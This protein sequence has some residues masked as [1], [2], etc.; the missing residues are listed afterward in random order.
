MSTDDI[1]KIGSHNGAKSTFEILLDN[2]KF[3]LL[4]T[5]LGKY[6]LVKIAS[7]TSSHNALKLLLN[8]STYHL[9]V[10][11]LGH[12]GLVKIANS[13]SSKNILALFLQDS[14]YETLLDRVGQESMIKLATNGASTYL[15]NC[16][17][18]NS[19]YYKLINCI[20][21]ENLIKIGRSNC[22]KPILEFI[23]NKKLF[24][25]LSDKIGKNN[26]INIL[27]NIRDKQ[28]ISLISNQES[29]HKLLDRVSYPE[30]IQV[31]RTHAARNVLELILDNEIFDQLIQHLGHRGLL[32]IARHDGA[33][34]IF[35]FVV[36]RE[37]FSKL[38]SRITIAEFLKITNQ[39]GGKLVLDL[40]L[41][42]QKWTV[43][44]SFLTPGVL[45]KI[46][47][48]HLLKSRLEYFFLNHQTL[49]Q[50][51]SNVFIKK[52]IPLSHKD[53]N[54][55][56]SLTV[57]RLINT[58]QFTENE[59]LS[60]FKISVHF[61]YKTIKIVDN[62]ED[63][64]KIFF[65][66]CPFTPY[67]INDFVLDSIPARIREKK[68]WII[69]LC[70]LNRH[71][72]HAPLSINDLNYLKNY[73]DSKSTRSK[74]INRL[75]SITGRFSENDRLNT[76][77]LLLSNNWINNNAWIN[78]LLNLSTPLR[79]WFI[80]NGYH[81]IQSIL[82]TSY[83]PQSNPVNPYILYDQYLLLS[84]LK[85]PGIRS[86]LSTA[87]HS[88]FLDS[89]AHQPPCI[90]ST[91][92]GNQVLISASAT[93][94][95]NTIHWLNFVIKIYKM[96]EMEIDLYEK[97]VKTE[98]PYTLNLFSISEIKQYRTNLPTIMYKSGKILSTISKK[99]FKIFFHTTDLP[100]L[101]QSKLVARTRKRKMTYDS[102]ISSPRKSNLLCASAL[103][104]I[105]NDSQSVFSDSVWDSISFY[106]QPHNNP[107]LAQQ[108]ANLLFIRNDPNIPLHIVTQLT[109]YSPLTASKPSSLP[110][111]NFCELETSLD[112]STQD[113][114]F[115]WES[116]DPSAE[117]AMETCP[118]PEH[119]SSVL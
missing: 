3:K 6:N 83:L 97:S 57:D 78:R 70:E 105:L 82:A 89:E 21:K 41:D 44:K 46:S 29:F 50:F 48:N 65:E 16:I 66:N 62:H 73:T 40:L 91:E 33:K 11:R 95:L 56:I 28:I 96:I 59:V 101:P 43:I 79:K 102:S 4:E 55:T 111:L 114:S 42:D 92:E 31:I 87:Y 14:T 15:L 98:I 1:F 49:L 45:S 54:E 85:S 23:L 19:I 76:W 47:N 5:R 51:V 69:G 18:N 24:N 118:I 88:S 58:Y 116:F 90:L 34:N 93:T 53:P 108:I 68:L 36:N 13:T 74:T 8:S 26:L 115:D 25:S 100:L 112:F 2:N 75:L 27:I 110:E 81:Y 80:L 61:L 30:L 9:L 86:Y 84:C 99:S 35:D 10:D 117:N 63:E 39:N 72:T 77:K 38:L 103:L 113:I 106:L 37:L 20:G 12:D 17:L 119:I 64:I 109:M 71:C 32:N 67:S 52:F 22:I 7:N 107:T 104:L 94:P 60:L